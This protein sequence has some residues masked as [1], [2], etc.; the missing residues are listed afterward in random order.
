MGVVLGIATARDASPFASRRCFLTLDFFLAMVFGETVDDTAVYE[1][2][3]PPWKDGRVF[4]ILSR[5]GHASQK[6]WKIFNNLWIVYACH[7]LD[8]RL[9]RPAWRR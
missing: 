1:E 8:L 2:R 9:P 5:F 4:L 7:A 6:C 3:R